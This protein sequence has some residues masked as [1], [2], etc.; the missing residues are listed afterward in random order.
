MWDRAKS[1]IGNPMDISQHFEKFLH[2]F[3]TPGGQVANNAIIYAAQPLT[4]RMEVDW[5]ITK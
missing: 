3:S 4:I 2:I 5:P 1:M